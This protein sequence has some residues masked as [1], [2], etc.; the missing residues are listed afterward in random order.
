[1]LHHQFRQ[2]NDGF[3]FVEYRTQWETAN[4]QGTT[5]KKKHKTKIIKFLEIPLE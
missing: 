2:L 1:M 3:G 4:K 5:T